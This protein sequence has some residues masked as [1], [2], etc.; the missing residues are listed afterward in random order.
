MIKIVVCGICGRMGK[1]IA[2]LATEDANFK[3]VG[4]TEI[5]GCSFIGT[6]IGSH[7]QTKGSMGI[8]VSPDLEENIK[9]CECVIDFTSPEASL[10]HVEVCKKHK[11][12]IVIGATGITEEQKKT[13][14]KAATDIP[15]IVAP[16][17]SVGVNIVFELLS[18]AAKRLGP[19]YKIS[20]EETHHI[21]KKDK[22][23]GTAK[24]IVEIIETTGSKIDSVEA[25]REGEVF[26][27][28]KVRFESAQDIIEI[29]HSAKN[30]DIF[31]LG[32]LEAAK[33]L[34]GKPN[35]EYSMKDVLDN[36]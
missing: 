7:L 26:G 1:R 18:Q 16:N 15:I 17:M 11:I 2:S 4:V 8:M 9:D 27:D 29:T 6:D 14:L 32:A 33:F 36:K 10:E 34:A 22:P 23:S 35:G 20:V 12:P 31:A 5:I 30:R 28:H 25:F 24:K 19:E 21:H 3:L 13:M